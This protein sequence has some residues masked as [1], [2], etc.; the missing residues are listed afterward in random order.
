VLALKQR[1]LHRIL[2]ACLSCRI[3]PSTVHRHAWQ[4]V[5]GDLERLRRTNPSSAEYSSLR[6]YIEMAVDLPWAKATVDKHDILGAEAQLNADHFGL[7]KVR[8]GVLWCGGGVVWCGVVWC[9]VVWCGVVW[10]G[11]VW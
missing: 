9:G 8:C 10:C 3:P 5:T 2:T 11:E 7:D 6:S 4:V 1:L